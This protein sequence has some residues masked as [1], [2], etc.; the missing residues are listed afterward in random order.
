MNKILLDISALKEKNQNA[1]LG[2][3][4]FLSKNKDY[5]I[6]VIGDS[7]DTV[8]IHRHKNIVIAQTDTDD[9]SIEPEYKDIKQKNIKILLSLLKRDHYKSFVTYDSLDSLK[10]Y[11]NKYF[12]KKDSPMLVASYANFESHKCTIFG[13]LGFNDNPTENDLS[14][15]LL[16][17]KD[18]AKEIYNFSST[19][20]KYLTSKV[21]NNLINQ[22]KNDKDFEGILSPKDFYTANTDILL[23]DAKTCQTAI[24]SI[25]GAIET[26]DSFIKKQINKNVGYKIFSAMFK[27]MI[28]SFHLQIDQ[29]LTSGGITLLGYDKKIIFVEPD[30]I[31]MGIKTAI[32]S[33]IK[34]NK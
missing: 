19:K 30:T 9:I 24:Q 33:S 6:T 12:V 17:L 34:F 27:S 11:I 2:L 13:D 18:Y 1:I 14:S 31:A 29:K 32:D 4:I 7:N 26:Y 3:K 15:Y 28:S 5:E 22:F 8:T 16:E 10:P 25:R 20:F 21:N 23:C